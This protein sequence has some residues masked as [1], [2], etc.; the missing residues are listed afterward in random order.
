VIGERER[1]HIHFGGAFRQVF[2]A[3]S[4]IEQRVLGMNVKV[5]KSAGAL[6][7]GMDDC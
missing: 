4:A 2:D 7:H 3:I 1:G 5:A 6:T